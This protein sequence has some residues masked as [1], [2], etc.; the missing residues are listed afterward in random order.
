MSELPA[1]MQEIRETLPGW[2][3]AV[4]HPSGYGRFRFAVDA[5]EPYDLDSSRLAMH[6]IYTT[7]HGPGG[8]L[9]TAE[10]K[11]EWADYL[12]GLQREEDGLL[13]DPAMEA[14]A[15]KDGN[16]PTDEER[17]K[18]RWFTSRNGLLS[19]D[20]IGGKPK[21][22]LRIAESMH[23]PESI[24]QYLNDLH[25]HNPWGAGSWA[26]GT[27]VFQYLNASWGDGTA[28][29]NLEAAVRWLEAAQ[30]PVTGA[31]PKGSPAEPYRLI[32]GIFKIWLQ[33]LPISDMKVQYP[34]KVI[35]LCFRGVAECPQLQGTPDAC[36][37]FD[38][39]LVLATALYFT[40]H[41]RDEVM[42]LARKY[43]EGDAFIPLMRPDG[44]FSYCP[45]QSLERHG[46]L[47]LAPVKDQSDAAGCSLVTEAVAL[48][49]HLAGWRDAF[50]WTPCT[51]VHLG[52]K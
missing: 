24:V 42:E 11:Q 51:E 5:Y 25:W 33:V 35:D 20:F 29:A 1:W 6:A 47:H 17:Y 19:L 28:K 48:L 27:V 23:T 12:T 26:G 34:E 52:L 7:G 40:D 22:P 32:N 4:A 43:L 45:G 15:G 2:I 49:A 50:G 37:I 41:R 46:G 16:P 31:W 9:P 39:A 44:G 30:D 38:M 8:G 3:E 18:V 13:V 21:Y 14:H 10:Q 36:S